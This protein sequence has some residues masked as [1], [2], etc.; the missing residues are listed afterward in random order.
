MLH[1]FIEV[2][3]KFLVTDTTDGS[4]S[5]INRQVYKIVQVTEHAHF[6]KLGDAGEEC[7]LDIAVA[8]LQCAVAGFQRVA[9]FSLERLVADSL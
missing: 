9:I 5:V 7:K 8:R 1:T 6:S 4:V 3:M 2:R